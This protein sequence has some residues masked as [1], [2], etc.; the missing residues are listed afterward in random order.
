MS[1]GHNFLK[2]LLENGLGYLWFV[3]L[4][5]WGG[6]VSYISRVR[7]NKTPFSLVE[8][9]GEWTISGFAGLI[10]AYICAEMEFSFYVT[11]ALTGICGHMGGRAI[12]ILENWAQSKLPVPNERDL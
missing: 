3:L 10:T 8:L 5:L 1:E 12:F 2:V 4:A 11:A 7:K 9:L 6:T